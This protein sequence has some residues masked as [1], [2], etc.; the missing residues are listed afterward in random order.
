M[1]NL[2]YIER[3]I[4]MRKEMPEKILQEAQQKFKD[5][6]KDYL[7]SLPKPS[8]KERM[9]ELNVIMNR[10]CDLNVILEKETEDVDVKKQLKRMRE[11]VDKIQ[12]RHYELEEE[13]EEKN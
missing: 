2:E 8:F 11:D 9:C 4:A 13:I 7:K 3:K 10:Y 6:L 5:T 12:D 1:F